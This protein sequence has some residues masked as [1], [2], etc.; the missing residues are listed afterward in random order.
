MATLHDINH[1][2]GGTPLTHWDNENDASN[3]I[4]VGAAGALNGTANGLIL[5]PTTADTSNVWS[6]YTPPASNEIRGRIY[7]D[8]NGND[9]AINDVKLFVFGIGDGDFT[10]GNCLFQAYLFYDDLISGDVELYAFYGTNVGFTGFSV[11]PIAPT[12]EPHCLV[13]LNTGTMVYY[14]RQQAISLIVQN[15]IT[16]IGFMLQVMVVVM[17]L[18]MSMWMKFS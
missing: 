7:F 13:K 14:K 16:R 5:D 9:P 8:Q 2:S 6:T 18:Q 10:L 3:L 11:N 1:N 15:S 17:V 12:D 4:T